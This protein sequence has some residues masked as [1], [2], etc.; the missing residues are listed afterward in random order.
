MGFCNIYTVT[1]FKNKQEG[2]RDA[3]NKFFR[4]MEQTKHGLTLEDEHEK[5]DGKWEGPCRDVCKM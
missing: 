4:K 1:F 3:T 5:G 2:R